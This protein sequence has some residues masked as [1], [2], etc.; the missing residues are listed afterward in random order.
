MYI[1]LKKLGHFSEKGQQKPD[2]SSLE[3]MLIIGAFSQILDLT[4]YVGFFG[5][6]IGPQLALKL[7]RTDTL[8]WYDTTF[9]GGEATV[10]S[11]TVSSTV[12]NQKRSLLQ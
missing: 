7:L 2:K 3:W 11:S 8:G 6:P 12:P 1:L 5:L 10:S 4:N 9:C